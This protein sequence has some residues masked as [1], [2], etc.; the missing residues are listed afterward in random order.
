MQSMIK[1]T[2]GASPTLLK[3]KKVM[4][5][6][7]VLFGVTGYA[8]EPREL[9]IIANSEIEASGRIARY[10][11]EKRA[12]P[13]ENIIAL[14]LGTKLTTTISRQDYNTKLAEPVRTLLNSDKFKGK[15]KCLLT[16]YGVPIIVDGRGQLPGKEKDL[17]AV[18][19]LIEQGSKL[20]AAPPESNSLTII[21]SPTEK[22]IV[23]EKL[24]QLQVIADIINGKETSASVDSELSMVLFPDYE[25]YRWQINCL[26]TSIKADVNESANISKYAALT[27]MVSRLDGPGEKIITGLIDKALAAEQNGLNGTVYLDSRGLTD[28]S[29]YGIYDQSLRDLSV[30]TKLRTKLP[31]VQEG[32]SQLFAAG[33]CPQTAV[34]CGWYSLTKY[35][36][37]FDFVDGAVGYHI[38]S[39]EARALRDPNSSQWCPAML[40]D[41]ITATLGPVE[42]PYLHSFPKPKDFFGELYDGY[43]LVEAYYHTNPINSW[44]MLLIGDP[45]YRPFKKAG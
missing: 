35:V 34:Y 16:I 27:T 12:V 43:C 9:L 4:I 37:A 17:K 7:V 28:N 18:E 39:Y 19:T 38:A 44:R 21:P 13:E 30:V 2:G 36:D 24:A 14:Q 41:G 8:L 23:E 6:L 33:A 40:V 29:E 32:T 22:K 31:V 3:H 10:Y 26:N 1:N 25:L 20:I 5:L 42:E 11:S 45:L 15:I